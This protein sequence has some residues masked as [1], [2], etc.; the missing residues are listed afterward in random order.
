MIN[1]IIYKEF[2]TGA[3]RADTLVSNAGPA[4]YGI[5]VT[6]VHVVNVSGPVICKTELVI[7]SSL[8]DGRVAST[9]NGGEALR[10][11]MLG[12]SQHTTDIS[13]CYRKVCK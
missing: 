9:V 7:V 2:Q 6:L 11:T 3:V 8:G 13:S 10:T 5:L 1:K 4:T 12:Q